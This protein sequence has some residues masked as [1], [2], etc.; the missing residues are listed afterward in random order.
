MGAPS[1]DSCTAVKYVKR[2]RYRWRVHVMLYS[3]PSAE[4]RVTPE[5]FF[6][7]N[8]KTKNMSYLSFYNI[9]KNTRLTGIIFKRF[10]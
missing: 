10:I 1:H 7:I 4:S 9:I 5:Q 8:N 6:P 3:W 2:K